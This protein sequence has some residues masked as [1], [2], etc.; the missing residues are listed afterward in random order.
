MT[1][2]PSV[3][4]VSRRAS[5]LR[6][7]HD[8]PRMLVL[9]N[10]WDAASARAFATAGF[11]AIATTSGGVAVALG[12]QDHEGAPAG[13]MLAAAARIIAAVDVPVTVDFESGYKLDPREIAQRLIAVGAA[14]LNLEDSD[15]SLA[16]KLVEADWQAERIASLKAAAKAAGV[17]LVLNARVDVF[18]HRIGGPDVQLAEGLRRAK[19]YRQAG[20][21]CIYPITLNDEGMLSR[22]VEAVEVVNINVRPGGP[23][24][25]ER[26][27]GLGLRRVSYATSIFREAMNLVG[28]ITGDVKA[29]LE[30][31]RGGKPA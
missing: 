14:G 17:D 15:H 7:L 1:N 26:A 31:L 9:L 24:S 20:A 4:I 21:D 12:Y 22:F 11:G 8:G 27:S 30:S 10:A 3:E 28:R 5:A 18:L 29:E 25:L 16:G 2:L 23:V 19:L 13:E 6:A